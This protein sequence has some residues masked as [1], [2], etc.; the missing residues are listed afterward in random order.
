MS[1]GLRIPLEYGRL[2]LSGPSPQHQVLGE[3]GKPFGLA[4]HLQGRYSD[5]VALRVRGGGGGAVPV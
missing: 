1:S 5:N 4:R 2:M 3:T